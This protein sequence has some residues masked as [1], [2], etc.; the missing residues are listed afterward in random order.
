MA[1]NNGGPFIPAILNLHASSE[2]MGDRLDV[3]NMA[4]EIVRMMEETFEGARFSLAV[5]DEIRRVYLLDGHRFSCPLLNPFEISAAGA[6][7][8]PAGVFMPLRGRDGL[9]GIL[10]GEG[11]AERRD[12]AVA[13]SRLAEIILSNARFFIDSEVRSMDLFRFSVLSRAL[14]PTVNED[15]VLK[16]MEEALRGM[17][18]F[19]ACGFLILGKREQT[20]FVKAKA[21]LDGPSLSFI[22]DNL[23][24]T[25]SSLTHV[26]LDPAKFK[27]VIQAPMSN[28]A[29][30]R[31]IE[32]I[33]NAPLITKG[34]VL[35]VMTVYGFAKDRFS[36]REQRNFSILAAHGAVAFE[37]AMLYQDLKRTYFSIINAL[38]S[39]IEAK[40]EYTRGHSVLVSKYSVAI[41][42]AMGLTHSV[43]ESIQIAGLLH[44]LGKIGV[45]EDILTKPGKL[46][47]GEYVIVKAHPEIAMKILGPVEFPHFS[48]QEGQREVAP[49]LTLSL[50]E[51]ADL[52]ADVKLMIFHHHEK[53]A[54]GGY[55][56][57]LKGEEIP[58]GARI[59]SVSDTFE[60]LTADR[61]YRKAFPVEQAMKIL[62]EISGEQLDPSI[63]KVFDGIVKQGGIEA[64]KNAPDF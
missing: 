29:I 34:K 8:S 18:D 60:A 2:I 44:D 27:R 47:D 6:V 63:V 17:V 33:I 7:D 30:G 25:I 62:N 42:A 45:P 23:F 38:T 56:K 31:K 51:E 48:D 15:E 4:R 22:E 50:F 52:S 59:L 39:A 10:R 43:V 46:T 19:D 37:N 9:L 16:I 40:D 36:M 28:L 26:N 3:G 58:L 1:D 13:Y 53:F 49:E 20:C 41:A 54:G 11:L 61:T 12:R 24:S 14:N 21:P 64:L 55:P 57:G 35:G 32:S 5:W